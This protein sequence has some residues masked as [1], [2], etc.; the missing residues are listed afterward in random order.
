MSY[1]E[2]LQREHK[3]RVKRM[4]SAAVKNVPRTHPKVIVDN[5]KPVVENATI[6]DDEYLSVIGADHQEMVLSTPQKLKKILAEVAQSH[7]VSINDLLAHR[8]FHDLVVARQ[9]FC[10]RAYSETTWSLPRIGGFMGR[11][12][13]TILW[14]I[15]AHCERKGVPNP[16][17]SSLSRLASQRK[18]LDK[19]HSARRLARQQQS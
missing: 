9:E 4:N 15:A 3:E 11:D 7:G 6:S 19:V 16:R 8:R 17:A 10:Y 2:Q 12:H 13:T 18:R 5:V 1:V 14:A